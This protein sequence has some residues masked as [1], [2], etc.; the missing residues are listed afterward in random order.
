MALFNLALPHPGDAPDTEAIPVTAVSFVLRAAVDL[1]FVTEAEKPQLLPDVPASSIQAYVAF[2]SFAAPKHSSTFSALYELLML[3]PVPYTHTTF[4]IWLKRVLLAL[5]LS[6]WLRLCFDTAAAHRSDSAAVE[7]AVALATAATNMGS[8]PVLAA[9]SLPAAA[10]AAPRPLPAPFGVLAAANSPAASVAASVHGFVLGNRCPW[11][12]PAAYA[13]VP[14]SEGEGIAFFDAEA[15]LE[16]ALDGVLARDW[17]LMRTTMQTRCAGGPELDA[18]ALAITTVDAVASGKD[19]FHLAALWRTQAPSLLLS[20]LAAAPETAAAVAAGTSAAGSALPAAPLP[21]ISL[22]A[23]IDTARIHGLAC[24]ADLERLVA[25]ARVA[26]GTAHTALGFIASCERELAAATEALALAKNAAESARGP[27]GALR[28]MNAA[29]PPAVAA[30]MVRFEAAQKAAQVTRETAEGAVAAAITASRSAA[31]A[32]SSLMTTLTASPT[33][34]QQAFA[35][36]S[37]LPVNAST[38]APWLM[39]ATAMRLGGVLTLALDTPAVA[40]W[41]DPTI[42]EAARTTGV[43]MASSYAAGIFAEPVRWRLNSPHPLPGG[44]VTATDALR[45]IDA[46]LAA[47]AAASRAVAAAEHAARA[48]EAA[49]ADVA[50][51]R[52]EVSAASGS[53]DAA[54]AQSAAGQLLMAESARTAAVDAA[55]VAQAES[56]ERLQAQVRAEAVVFSLLYDCYE[57]TTVSLLARGINI[58]V[59]VASAQRPGVLDALAENKNAPVALA[60]VNDATT[61]VAKALASFDHSHMLSSGV[62]RLRGVCGALV[63]L[64]SPAAVGDAGTMQ[65]HE[66]AAAVMLSTAHDPAHWRGVNSVLFANADNFRA[67]APE[68]QASMRE[69]ERRSSGQQLQQHGQKNARSQGQRPPKGSTPRRR[70]AQTPGVTNSDAASSVDPAPLAS[71]AGDSDD[72]TVPFGVAAATASP[73]SSSAAA[74]AAAGNGAGV[75]TGVDDGAGAGA[76]D[77]S[78]GAETDELD[79]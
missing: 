37:A 73:S 36:N 30:A 62:T 60:L 49:V 39:A 28:R 24:P 59:T 63:L 65:A 32:L 76:G 58:A 34:L 23:A 9:A 29:V 52:E 21:L 20:K 17:G 72:S 27:A 67:F 16:A 25:A 26:S 43:V 75:G 2:A 78:G 77:G 14:A 61:H 3:H 38:V 68:V 46:A 5:H 4:A 12:V 22:A 48:R 50:R 8:T 33:V 64:R 45:A 7:A 40:W 41:G 54:R 71:K 47:G 56:T 19:L 79:E 35:A 66:T 74:A 53:G 70:P 18:A 57:N 6:H 55:N 10:A 13:P 11:S 51:A 42:A 15:A 69:Q 31:R 1:S 44:L